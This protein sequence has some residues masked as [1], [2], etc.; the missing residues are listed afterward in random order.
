MASLIA[1]LVLGLAAV[2][3]FYCYSMHSAF[4]AAK[5]RAL[6]DEAGELFAFYLS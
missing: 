3:A 2:C 4:V 1:A 5:E 6:R